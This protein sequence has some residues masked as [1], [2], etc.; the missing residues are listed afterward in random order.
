[1]TPEEIRGLQAA[2]GG[3]RISFTCEASDMSMTVPLTG[4]ASTQRRKSMPIECSRI[5]TNE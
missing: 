3:L 4:V 2:G 1:M 5:S